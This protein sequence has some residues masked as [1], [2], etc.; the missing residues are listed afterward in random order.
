MSHPD[1]QGAVE[2]IGVRIKR[3][4][5]EMEDGR[6]GSDEEPATDAENSSSSS[7]E[8]PAAKV[9]RVDENNVSAAVEYELHQVVQMEG[10]ADRIISFLRE[11]G[12][13]SSFARVNKA[14]LNR[15]LRMDTTFALQLQNAL[16]RSQRD[17]LNQ[18]K[19]QG[20]YVDADGRIILDIDDSAN[21]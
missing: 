8:E 14:Q 16:V 19:A 15:A 7:S 12:E 1:V 2:L 4:R 21:W 6:N 11:R 10:I 13:R 18:L 3:T 5:E 9:L 20:D 17:S